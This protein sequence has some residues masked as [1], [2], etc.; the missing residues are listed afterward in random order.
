M[1]RPWAMRDGDSAVSQMLADTYGFG[2]LL[3]RTLA[4]R[5]ITT[6]AEAEE[7]LHPNL[8]RDWSDPALIPGMTAVADALENAI[9]TRKKILIFGDFDVDGISA[10]ACMLRGLASFGVAADYVIP[11]RAGEGY[12]LTAAAL[13]RVYEKAPEVLVTVDCGI[14]AREEVAQLC[15]RGIEVLITD[16]HEPS[17]DVPENIPVADPKLE[18]DSPQALLAGVSVALK[19]IALL[20]ERFDQPQLWR[21]LVDL[22]TLGTLADVMPLL[23][24]NRSLVAEGTRLIRNSP[25]PGI[26]SLLALAK[27]DS[28]SIT[29]TDLAFSLIPRLN[30]AGRM[31]E[32]TSA[33]ELLTDDDPLRAQEAACA[34]DELNNSRRA[35]ESSLFNEALAQADEFCRDQKAVIV[36]GENWHEGVRGIVASRLASHYGVPAIVFSIVGDEARGSGRSVG[37]VNLFAALERCADLTLRFGGHEAAVGVTIPSASLDR[38]RERMAALMK[39]TPE[40]NFHS[41]RLVDAQLE[42]SELDMQTVEQLSLLE[43]CGHANKE[44]L[45]V[46][47]NAFLKNARAVGAQKNHLSF[48]LTKGTDSIQAIWFQ[49]PIID[50]LIACNSPVDVVYRP[51]IDEF[52][53]T[54]RVKLIVEDADVSGPVRTSETSPTSAETDVCGAPTPAPANTPDTPNTPNSEA[55]EAST[56]HIASKI[57]GAPVRL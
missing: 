19:L 13:E 57:I 12:G 29:S 18:K 31:G 52:N 47:R 26:A 49:C 27:R 8:E 55:S 21:D 50:E 54:R 36:A 45:F 25:R 43:P 16:H 44:P 30:A 5:G 3:A 51:Q 10:T 40:E 24:E 38:F 39:E 56:L 33:L 37:T 9:R 7:F 46:T 17:E 20:G 23:G 48:S 11:R 28:Q 6:L 15:A 14:S 1:I 2:S 32:A 41:P 34:L 42:L 22:A 4:A 35:V 53:G